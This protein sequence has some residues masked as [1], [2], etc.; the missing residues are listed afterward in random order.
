MNTLN[1]FYKNSYF[2]SKA[3]FYKNNL[4][5]SFNNVEIS[6]GNYSISEAMLFKNNKLQYTL[7]DTVI[8]NQII[9]RSHLKVNNNNQLSSY[10]KNKF[11]VDIIGD[12][13]F[14]FILTGN[15]RNLDLNLKLNSDLTNSILKID[16][17]N[18][19]KKKNIISSIKTEI[20]YQRGRLA[21][22]NDLI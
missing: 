11:N 10:L 12:I 18:L 13:E 14:N 9:T 6:E 4:K 1:Y 15:I 22:I 17:L 19:I 3:N 16:Y 21:L 2:I 7:E 8:N 5:Y 20:I